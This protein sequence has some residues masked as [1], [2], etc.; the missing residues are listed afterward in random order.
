MI[1]PETVEEAVR[2]E[3]GDGYE[4]GWKELPEKGDTSTLLIDGEEFEFEVVENT[5]SYEYPGGYDA[6]DYPDHVQRIV[7]H[8]PGTG[9]FFLKTG[10]YQSFLG[11]N[12]EELKGVTP[13]QQTITVWE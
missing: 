6:H 3:Y 5:T 9:M 7:L 13:R 10:V 12:W 8:F 4:Y 11:T 2:R 1:N